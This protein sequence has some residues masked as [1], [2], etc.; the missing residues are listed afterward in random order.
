MKLKKIDSYSKEELRKL[1]INSIF[2]D[3]RKLGYSAKQSQ[4]YGW[5]R[6]EQGWGGTYKW[7]FAEIYTENKVAFTEKGSYSDG[8]WSSFIKLYVKGYKKKDFE[9]ISKDWE[10]TV[11]MRKDFY[12]SDG[13]KDSQNLKCLL[14][15]MNVNEKVKL[16]KEVDKKATI[17]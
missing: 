12:L 16:E 10:V 3:L 4:N 14:I 5:V 11:T 2:R 13:I 9:K 6:N 1:K 15:E 8:Y 7:R 17:S